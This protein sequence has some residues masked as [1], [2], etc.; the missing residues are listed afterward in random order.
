MQP[1][2]VTAANSLAFQAVEACLRGD[3]EYSLVLLL[4]PRG[5]GKSAL[6]SWA[7]AKAAAEPGAAPLWQDPLE[8]PPRAGYPEGARLVA[9]LDTEA[10]FADELIARFRQAGGRIVSTVIE[11]ELTEAVARELAAKLSLSIDD[12]ALRLVVDR[13]RTPSIVNGALKRL[14]AEAALAGRGQIDSLFVIRTLG[15]FLFPSR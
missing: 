12:E 3:P 13:L 2:F 10:Y 9:T 6:V 8:A 7:R 5:S 1:F 11:P 4:G 14:Q 15:S